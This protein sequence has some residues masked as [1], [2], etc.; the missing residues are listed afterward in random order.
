MNG[1]LPKTC[2]RTQTAFAQRTAIEIMVPFPGQLPKV[3]FTLMYSNILQI[4]KTLS[5]LNHIYN[6][7]SLS[8]RIFNPVQIL[9]TYVPLNGENERDG[10]KK[11]TLAIWGQTCLNKWGKHP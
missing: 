1:L 10:E 11:R 4:T 2:L 8:K 5:L 7:V 9:W 3:C 6:I